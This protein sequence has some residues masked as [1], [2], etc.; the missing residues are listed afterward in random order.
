M[1]EHFGRLPPP[2]GGTQRTLASTL[3]IRRSVSQGALRTQRSRQTGLLP[4]TSSHLS[5]TGYCRPAP[6]LPHKGLGLVPPRLSG[7]CPFR[8]G[9]SSRALLV[10]LNEIAIS[11]RKYPP[12]SGTSSGACGRVTLWTQS[13]PTSAREALT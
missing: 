6:S 10:E 3:G 5:V 2:S 4:A 7:S 8:E 1:E 9:P 11:Q 12:H 13:G